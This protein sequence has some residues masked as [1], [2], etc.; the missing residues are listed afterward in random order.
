ML[1]HHESAAALGFEAE[2]AAFLAELRAA[3]VH[4]LAALRSLLALAL[5]PAERANPS[6]LAFLREARL[7][8]AQILAIPDPK[9]I[10]GTLPAPTPPSTPS[11]RP[12]SSV[13]SAASSSVAATQPAAPSSPSSAHTFL[14]PQRAPSADEYGSAPRR[15]AGGC[16][17]THERP[18]SRQLAQPFLSTALRRTGRAPPTLRL[19]IPNPDAR[20]RCAA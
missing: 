9:P 11:P 3:R 19:N 17:F 7:A 8:A 20:L 13:E 15:A 2:E 1:A 14:I 4:A 18:H 16:V 5:Q 12:A 10:N 6:N